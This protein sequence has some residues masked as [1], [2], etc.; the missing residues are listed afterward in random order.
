MRHTLGV[1]HTV[2]WKWHGLLARGVLLQ[3]DY[4]QS[5][6]AC[7]AVATVQDFKCLP[8]PPYTPNMAPSDYHMFG[9]L[10]EALG[11]KKFRSDEE[12]QQVVHEWLCG[13]PQEFFC[14]GI[15][16]LCT[17]PRRHTEEWRYSCTFFLP[18]HQM[19]VSAQHYTVATLPIG[20]YPVGEIPHVCTC[21]WTL[22]IQHIAHCCA[23]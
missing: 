21:N 13:Q 3:D 1:L 18:W 11:V 10:K 17:T 22:A 20:K 16:T 14:R 19:E 2:R 23:N 4:A 8:Y 9:P 5:H 7:A 15:H 12:V 6:T